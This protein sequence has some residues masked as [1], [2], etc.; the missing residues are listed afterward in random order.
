MCLVVADHD[1]RIAIFGGGVD[2]VGE[3]DRPSHLQLADTSAPLQRR[4]DDQPSSA[5]S[6]ASITAVRY[7]QPRSPHQ[8]LVMS[9]IGEWNAR[10]GHEE[11]LAT[12]NLTPP[13]HRGMRST[14]ASR[15]ID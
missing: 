12:S 8:M 7:P 9:L 2:A 4:V 15:F 14:K 3:R 10:R 5:R 11:H 6:K 1:G 13:H